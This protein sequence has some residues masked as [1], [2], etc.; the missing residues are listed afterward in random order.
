M[1]VMHH[2]KRAE[3]NDRIRA[4]YLD[5]NATTPIASEVSAAMLPFI[6]THFG[7]P[8]SDHDF[9]H[10]TAE[11]V[12]NA[13]RQ[14]ADLLGCLANEIVF[15]GGGS[16]SDNMALVGSVWAADTSSP[17]IVTSTVEHPA[18][19]TTCRFL[20]RK[21]VDITYVPVDRY[22]QV[23]PDAIRDAIR[24]E[25]VVV[26]IM[27]ANNETGS[28]QPIREI[29]QICRSAG[30][31]FHTDASQSVGKLP[32]LVDDLGIDMLTIAGHKLYAPKGIG[33]MYIRAG[34][35][36]EPLIHGAGH[37][38]G[39]RAGT[40]N[41]PYIVGLG[42]AA[43]LA[44]RSIPTEEPRQRQLRDRL[45]DL[46]STN[47]GDIALTGHPTDRLPNTLNV[48]F[49][50]VDGNQLLAATPIVAAST[51][52]A[53]HAGQ[54]EPSPVLLAMGIDPAD[55]VGAVRLSLGRPTTL[56]E[57]ESAAHALAVSARDM[58]AG[59]NVGL[60]AKARS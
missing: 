36:V 53:C 56:E 35:S 24:P 50:G 60:P 47:P 6:E 4:I 28:L 34:V 23:D 3:M 16:E 9:G 27:H 58:R 7:N 49:H 15:T 30:V 8:S 48:R 26:S 59:K 55:A 41:V 33:A 12:D 39:R 1:Y 42:A 14:V 25:T 37:E 17:H 52:S 45:F 19:L 18:I 21:G 54:S 13:R 5:Y 20:E 51:G 38:H 44:K 57:I 43:E 2:A 40:E 46:L 32:T 31:P 22:G 29:A 10:V 11:A